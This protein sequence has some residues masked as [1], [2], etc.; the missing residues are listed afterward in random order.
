MIIDA[1]AHIIPS[2]WTGSDFVP[3]AREK[4]I[5]EKIYAHPEGRLALARAN[6]EKLLESMSDC[7]IDKA[8]IMGLPWTA[9]E[10]NQENNRYIYENCKNYPDKFLG[11]GIIDPG[12]DRPVAAE[13]KKFKNEYGFKGVKVIPSWQNFTLDS[14]VFCVWVEEIIRHDLVLF[15][16]ISYI[17]S[18]YDADAPQ[19]LFNL[20]RRFPEL[21]IIAPHL[22]GL[23]CFHYLFEPVKKSLRNVRFVTSVSETM[24]LVEYAAEILPDEMLV[25]GTDYPFQPSH[26]QATVLH[27]F[28]EL[29]MANELRQKIYSANLMAFLGENE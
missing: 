5:G 4:F 25:F 19:R 21:K 2:A 20:A 9:P 13:L 7:G 3:D 12:A 26:D 6:A 27:K 29:E 14:D 17:V 8:L 1:E 24:K 23:L 10:F 22:G 18:D 16:H 28:T 15:P 11:L